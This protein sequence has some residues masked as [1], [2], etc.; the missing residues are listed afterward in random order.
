MALDREI[1][2]AD[3]AARIGAIKHGIMFKLQMRRAFKRHRTADMNI[4]RFDVS[5]REAERG[6]KFK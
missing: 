5:L 1:A 6:E 2:L 4:G 3:A